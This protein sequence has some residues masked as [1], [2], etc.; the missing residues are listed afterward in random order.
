MKLFYQYCTTA[1]L[2][3]AVVQISQSVYAETPDLCWGG[4]SRACSG[5]CD[6][7][8]SGP[9]SS[10]SVGGRNWASL[11]FLLFFPDGFDSPPL[12]AGSPAGTARPDVGRL[13]FPGTEVLLGNERLAD[14]AMSGL[15]LSLGHWLD[16]CGKTAIVGSVFG[17]GTNSGYTYPDNPDSIISRP[18][19][20]ADPGI[21]AFDSELVNLPGVVDGTISVLA[22][23]DILSGAVG[24]QKNLICEQSCDLSRRVDF[25]VGYRAFSLEDSLVITEA[26]RST[27]TTGLL[28]LDTTFDVLDDFESHNDFHGVE[29]GLNGQWQRQQWTLSLASRVA[30]GNVRQRIVVDGSTTT[31]VPGQDPAVLPY[32]ILAAS[33]NIGEYERD[34]FGVMTQTQLQI[35]YQVA[36][37]VTL[38]VGY[39]FIYLNDVARVGDHIDT[40][41][42][43]TLI[44]PIVADTDPARPGFDWVS[45]S[46]FLHGFNVGAEF[47]F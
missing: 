8:S 1:I 44:D 29:L 5:S 34:R 36:Q 13:D 33:S 41:V 10:S 40:T 37:C 14:S 27:A 16:D 26:L 39:N 43:G 24:L 7:C 42:N 38:K 31:S 32:G 46:L 25:F 17:M 3:L 4:G 22:E 15:R 28:A 21:N 30:L 20:N 9:V 35:G 12:V 6:H 47:R 45:E 11:D 2:L 18:F 19:F 23:T